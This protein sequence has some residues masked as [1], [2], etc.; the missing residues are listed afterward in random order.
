MEKLYCQR[1]TAA[2]LPAL[3]TA[4]DA[5]LAN[6]NSLKRKWVNQAGTEAL[7]FYH[8]VYTHEFNNGKL[9]FT[10]D[11]GLLK[12]YTDY[13][14]ILNAAG[15]FA[16]FYIT[17]SFITTGPPSYM[18]W[19][20]VL[21]LLAD[22]HD[23][24]CHTA[25]HPNL[26]TL[27]EAQIIA[28]YTQVNADFTAHGIPLPLHTAY[29]NGLFNGYVIRATQTMRLT[30]RTY[31]WTPYDVVP[32]ERDLMRY[33]F[34]CATIDN[35]PGFVL[36]SVYNCIDLAMDTKSLLVLL[37]HASVTNAHLTSIINYAQAAGIDIITI[38]QLYALL[39]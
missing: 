36:E 7:L 21:T 5:F 26:P 30:G 28:E 23:I 24:E 4:C 27:T 2:N 22:G 6:V 1:I 31:W 12:Q 9:V 39:V 20:N 38:P 19:A 35:T 10:W 32:Q 16:T 37:G 34:N 13:R 8:G 25:T 17:T 14:G 3:D 18:T 11:N 33:N 29:P 15:I